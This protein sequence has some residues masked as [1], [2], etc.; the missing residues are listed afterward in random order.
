[1]GSVNR[2]LETFYDIKQIMEGVDYALTE[3]RDNDDIE[4]DKLEI[5]LKEE[6]I[7]L[8]YKTKG[9]KIVLTLDRNND[10]LKLKKQ[11]K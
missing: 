7:N 5:L 2:T 8:S 1:M 10:V 11:P 4:L 9:D 3:L 6:G